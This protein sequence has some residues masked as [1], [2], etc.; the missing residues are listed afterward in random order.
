M[1]KKG[2]T[3]VELLGTIVILG[4]LMSVAIAAYSTIRERSAKK[5]YNLL[6]K[7][8][9]DAAENYFLDVPGDDNITVDDLVEQDYLEPA[10][11]PWDPDKKC[12]GRVTK[13]LPAG[14]KKNEDSIDLYTFKVELK[15]TSGCTCLVYPDKNSCECGADL[16][17]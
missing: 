6:H 9:A 17:N 1:N 13:E 10:N 2:F 5:T 11:D 4:I 8:V 7:G 16:K 14:N 15:C 3:M 12:V